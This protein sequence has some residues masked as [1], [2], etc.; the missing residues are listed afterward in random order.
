MNAGE[1]LKEFHS[2]SDKI[3]LSF[4]VKNMP[5]EVIEDHTDCKWCTD[6]NSIYIIS[7]SGEYYFEIYGTSIWRK[8]GFVMAKVY[9]G[10]GDMYCL[11]MSSKNEVSIDSWDDIVENLN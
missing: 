7:V 11:I 5:I 4:G 6:G 2:I 9:S 10:S 3:W 1:L 8:N